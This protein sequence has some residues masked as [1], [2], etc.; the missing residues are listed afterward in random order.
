MAPPFIDTNWM[1]GRHSLFSTCLTLT[2]LHQ[3]C[4]HLPPCLSTNFGSCFQMA[5]H[6]KRNLHL[7]CI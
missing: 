2:V 5:T 4:P 7:S 3:P 6:L 1:V